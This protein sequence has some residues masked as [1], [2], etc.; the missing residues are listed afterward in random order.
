MPGCSATWSSRRSTTPRTSPSVATTTPSATEVN[1]TVTEHPDGSAFLCPSE[2]APHVHPLGGELQREPPVN[3]A[4][5]PREQL[6]RLDRVE[7]RVSTPRDRRTPQRHVLLHVQR[8][9]P[10]G[11]ARHPGRVEQHHCLRGVE[12]R[13][14]HHD[15]VHAPDHRL[16][17]HRVPTR[18]GSRGTPPRWRCPSAARPSSSGSAPARRARD[19]NPQRPRRLHGTE[20]GLRHR[21]LQSG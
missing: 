19:G 7:P 8:R 21:G 16:R 12:D 2:L 17:L 1:A 5:G 14:R 9:Q 20:L 6:L 3:V 10:S 18:P 4:H 11:L 15:R 13:Q